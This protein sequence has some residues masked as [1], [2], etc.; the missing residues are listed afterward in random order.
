M[1]ASIFFTAA[2]I[3]VN[4]DEKRLTGEKIFEFLLSVQVS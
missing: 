4:Y 2:M 1:G 3:R